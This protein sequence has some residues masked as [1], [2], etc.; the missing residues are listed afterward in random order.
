MR[1]MT[2]FLLVLLMAQGISAQDASWMYATTTTENAQK[3]KEIRPN[4]IQI[5]ETKGN[6]AAVYFSAAASAEIKGLTKSHGP[7]FIFQSNQTSA[8]ESLNAEVTFGSQVLDFT[9]SEEAYVLQCI[10]D[11]NVDNIATTILELEAYGT[12][13]HNQPTGIQAALDIKEK[14]EDMVIAA[15]RSDIS[16]SFYDHS[17]TQQKSVIVSIPGAEFPDEIVVIG[18][19]LDSGDYWSPYNA[20]G[21]DDNASGIATLTET[22]RV[23]LANDFRPKRTVQ[24]MGY[25]A[26]EIGLIGSAEIAHNYKNNNKNVLAVAQFDMTNYH[27]S[28]YDIG[29]VSDP[30]YTSNDLN[31]YLIELLE[32]YNHNGTHALTY[33]ITYCEY[34]CS[35]HVSWNA[36]GYHASFPMEAEMDETNPYIHSPQ[37]TFAMMNND[38]SHSAKFVKLALEFVIEIA[39]TN[40]LS[41][42]EVATADWS[43]VVHNQ[44]LIYDLKSAGARLNQLEIYDT[45]ARK[46]LSKKQLPSKGEI[47]LGQ[48][49]KGAYVAVFKDENGKSYTK[50]FLVR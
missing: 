1:K 11:V 4:E 36:N 47:A 39:K 10:N 27:G 20:P 17:Q 48:L 26:E 23:L 42:D 7:G 15:D 21:A 22:L 14:W 41:I 5:I 45:S 24:I 50:K 46:V 19:H 9:I 31:L 33:G 34:A 29:F 13:F 49:K 44:Q 35:D 8:I 28:T 25:A 2:Q 38:A 37:D 40:H 12:R 16:V 43:I 3:I 30:Q 6:H 32:H 18:G